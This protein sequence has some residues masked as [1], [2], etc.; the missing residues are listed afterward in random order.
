MTQHT[1]R[2]GDRVILSGLRRHRRWWQLWKPH[3][4][5]TP[6]QEWVVGTPLPEFTSVRLTPDCVRPSPPEEA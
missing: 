4:W 3:S 2:T 5:V 1:Y 6:D